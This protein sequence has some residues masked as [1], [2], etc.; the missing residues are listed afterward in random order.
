M[1]TTTQEL[2]TEYRFS[3]NHRRLRLVRYR[4]E[5]GTTHYEAYDDA[6]DV[7]VAYLRDGV[8]DFDTWSLEVIQAVLRRE[9][10]VTR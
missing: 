1:G 7:Q 6:A 3:S 10:L 8:L 2:L 9:A 4:D 5:D